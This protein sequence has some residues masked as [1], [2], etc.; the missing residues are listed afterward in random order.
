MTFW[1]GLGYGDTHDRFWYNNAEAEGVQTYPHGIHK[2]YDM[3]SM[4]GYYTYF[5]DYYIAYVINI[6]S[7]ILT[8]FGLSPDVLWGMK[9]GISFE[10][11]YLYL[12][13]P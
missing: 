4:E 8:P 7:S 5:I 13:L 10:N 6:L 1:T 12:L 9:E 11:V 2:Y 3:F